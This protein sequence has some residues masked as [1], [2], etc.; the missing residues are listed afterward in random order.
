MQPP[1]RRKPRPAAAVGIAADGRNRSMSC[2]SC[3]SRI[4]KAIRAVPGVDHVAVNLATERAAVHFSGAPNGE[5][6]AAAVRKAGYTPTVETTELAV[7]GMTCASCV[8]RVE[9]VLKKQPGVLTADVNLATERANV[10]YL[11]GAVTP[12]RWRR[13]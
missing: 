6:V 8:G 11:S 2:A 9:R 4:E 5:A 1:R 13:R 7:S 10:S 12:M 3:V